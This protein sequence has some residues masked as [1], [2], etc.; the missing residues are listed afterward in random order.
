[1][2]IHTQKVSNKSFFQKNAS[3]FKS[4]S[5]KSLAIPVLVGAVFQFQQMSI[6]LM[7]H[8]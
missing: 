7:M 5:I 6:S 8:Y 3:S 2:Y 1:M 4:I